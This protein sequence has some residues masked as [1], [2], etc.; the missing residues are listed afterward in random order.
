MSRLPETTARGRA[1]ARHHGPALGRPIG[2]RPP[3]PN[4]LDAD[5]Q[6]VHQRIFQRMLTS[7]RFFVG[8][9]AL[10]AMAGACASG[11]PRDP[12]WPLDCRPGSVEDLDK[13]FERGWH[14]VSSIH[15]GDEGWRTMLSCPRT[16]ADYCASGA[17]PGGKTP[18]LPKATCPTPLSS[19]HCEP[20]IG[21]VFGCGGAEMAGRGMLFVYDAKGGFPVAAVELLMMGSDLQRERCVAGP[22]VLPLHDQCWDPRALDCPRPSGPDNR[23]W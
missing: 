4:R 12:E 6:P 2:G 8:G 22:A 21:Y 23:I 15:F 1:A 5:T 7:V 20:Y 13:S 14:E 18:A 19:L 11:P 17:C 10:A 3:N 9:L 16:M